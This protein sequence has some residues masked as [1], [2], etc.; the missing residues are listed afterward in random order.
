MN[1][2]GADRRPDEKPAEQGQ[3]KHD[4]STPE[5]GRRMTE[6]SEASKNSG[7][8]RVI[9]STSRSPGPEGR[10]GGKDILEGD[11]SD[12]ESGR[13][14]QLEDDDESEIVYPASPGG[15]MR[16]VVCGRPQGVARSEALR[17]REDQR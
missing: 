13:P 12:R 6:V 16:G 10:G 5:S 14:I 11:R 4:P 8:P 7:R 15:L 1:K 17:G 9:P 2:K 3:G